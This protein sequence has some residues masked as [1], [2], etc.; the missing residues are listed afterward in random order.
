MLENI[1]K[2]I[3]IL[4]N[5]QTKERIIKLHTYLKLQNSINCLKNDQQEQYLQS[6]LVEE[7]L[8]Q[9]NLPMISNLMQKY[10]TLAFWVSQFIH[11]Q[12]LYNHKQINKSEDNCKYNDWSFVLEAIIDHRIKRISRR[13]KKV[14]ENGDTK[15]VLEGG[16]AYKNESIMERLKAFMA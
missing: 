11:L 6:L 2:T 16:K 13:V 12:N 4:I 9:L 8:Y 7:N 3:L 5:H 15:F 10:E 14:L 1:T